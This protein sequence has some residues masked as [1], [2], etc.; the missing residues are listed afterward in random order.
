MKRLLG[1]GAIL[2]MV[3][4]GKDVKIND[5]FKG[6]M[7]HHNGHQQLMQSG[8]MG[9]IQSHFHDCSNPYATGVNGYNAY[10]WSMYYRQYNAGTWLYGQ[11]YF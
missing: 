1:I 2:I 10:D 6:N 5:A 11:Y 8:N 3:S 4:C 9:Q 7:L